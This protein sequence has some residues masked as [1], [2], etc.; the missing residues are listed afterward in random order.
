MSRVFIILVLVASS[1][2]ARS[3]G[4]VE[5]PEPV[6]RAP[7]LS[8][9]PS[10]AP[11]AGATSVVVSGGGWSLE[12]K[13]P[14]GQGDSDGIGADA[15]PA[16]RLS[17]PR[18]PSPRR[19]GPP[20]AVAAP[21]GEPFAPDVYPS[22]HEAARGLGELWVTRAA[23]RWQREPA[24][25]RLYCCDPALYAAAA[26]GIRSRLPQARVEKARPGE[27]PAGF[28]EG[29]PGDGQAW[30]AVDTS[31]AAISVTPKK[32]TVSTGTLSLESKGAADA[33]V[34]A[35]FVEKA[36]LA[37]FAAFSHG[38]PGRWI[39]GRSDPLRPAMTEGEAARAARE[40]AATQLFDLVRPRLAGSDEGWLRRRLEAKLA[41]GGYV[42]DQFPQKFDR[43]FGST[44]RGAVLVDASPENLNRISHELFIEHRAQRKSVF[45][46]AASAGGVLLV[47]YSLYRLANA[48]TR[49]YFVWSLRTAA[50]VVASVAVVLIRLIQG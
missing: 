27:C 2:G 1:G 37:N 41:G 45:V 25:I 23:E 42:V 38:Q 44:W 18:L 32:A 40:A 7:E 31:P 11:P 14:S 21:P 46:S 9:P 17:A 49:G 24:T 35:K 19:V 13:A 50:A 33:A 39:V 3:T 34:S 8:P 12:V 30:I 5:P 48:F 15:V 16:P 10:T 36:W 6:M 22:E 20:V 26:S 43:R 4:P 47:T 28:H 29:Q